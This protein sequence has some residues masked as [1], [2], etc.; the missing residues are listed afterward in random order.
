MKK[1][2]KKKQIKGPVSTI[3]FLTSLICVASLVLS[4]I[5]FQG[6]KTYI[7]NDSLET[8]LVVVR[9]IISLEG[10]KF[11]IGNVVTNFM[12]FEPLCVMIISLV[13]IGIVEKSGLLSAI[14]HKIKNIKFEVVIFLTLLLGIVS[15]IIGEYSYMFIIPLIGLMYK[16]LNRSP[17]LG[18]L[19]VFIGITM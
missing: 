6:N 17:V 7:G 13:G 5:G 10:L 2:K 19:T 11:I 8:S 9:N 16:Y 18:I 14:F 1:K 3:L 15:S 4:L 12:N